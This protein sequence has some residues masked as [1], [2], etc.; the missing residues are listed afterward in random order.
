M[1]NGDLILESNQHNNSLSHFSSQGAAGI[2]W[3]QHETPVQTSP[4]DI[5]SHGVITSVGSKRSNGN[6]INYADSWYNS[7]SNVIISPHSNSS[8]SSPVSTP[9]NII[10]THP[11]VDNYLHYQ[12]NPNVYSSTVS[13]AQQYTPPTTTTTATATAT[14]TTATTTSRT[15]QTHQFRIRNFYRFV[16]PNGRKRMCKLW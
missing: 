15:T 4:Y 6:M 12:H 3:G 13:A 10:N 14:A 2:W 11:S 8:Q 16:F 1:A 9:N 5:Q 7:H